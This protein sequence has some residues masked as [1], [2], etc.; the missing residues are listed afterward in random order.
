LGSTLVSTGLTASG[1][2]IAVTQHADGARSAA[3]ADGPAGAWQILPPLPAGTDVVG[4][5][6]DGQFDALISDQST[7]RVDRLGAGGWS[8]TQTVDV[9]I[10][11]GSSG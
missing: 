5:T 6:A 1:Q 11:Y 9:P 3:V 10:Q 4:T 7:L 2:L 8:R